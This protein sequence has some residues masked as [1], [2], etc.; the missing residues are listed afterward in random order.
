MQ[1][2]S[3][4]KGDYLLLEAESVDE[5]LLL[6]FD[7]VLIRAIDCR[8]FKREFI[9]LILGLNRRLRLSLVHGCG[10]V[11]V[12]TY[13]VRTVNAIGGSAVLT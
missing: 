4:S 10:H 8:L 13:C 1:V 2:L 9:L 7:R 5:R 12:E 3:V 6:F 11:P